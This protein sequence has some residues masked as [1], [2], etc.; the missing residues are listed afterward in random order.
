MGGVG[1]CIFVL[2]KYNYYY[3]LYFYFYTVK[4]KLQ[5]ML[6]ENQGTITAAVIEDALDY[7]YDKPQ[8]FFEDLLQHGCQ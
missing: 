3:I 1:C 6:D 8:Q 5:K 7:G 4:T 2:F